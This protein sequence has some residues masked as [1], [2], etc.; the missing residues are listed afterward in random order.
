MMI[1]L[2]RYSRIIH[3]S[4]QVSNDTEKMLKAQEKELEITDGILPTQLFCVNKDVDH[5]NRYQTIMCRR[6]SFSLLHKSPF[7]NTAACHIMAQ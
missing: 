2:P 1:C 5:I 4:G 3:D 7:K 6:R